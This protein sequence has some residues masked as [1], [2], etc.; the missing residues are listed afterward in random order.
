[1]I[2]LGQKVRDRLTKFEGVVVGRVEYLTGCA[3]VLV[4]PDV[5]DK[6]AWVESRWMDEPRM[7]VTHVHPFVLVPPDAKPGADTPAPRR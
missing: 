3:Q 7:L 1:M 6:G 4:Q 2:Q 5:D